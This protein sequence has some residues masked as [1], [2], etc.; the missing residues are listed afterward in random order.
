MTT[1]RIAVPIAAVGALAAAALLMAQ[2]SV[3]DTPH[4]LSAS[5]PSAVRATGEEKVCIFCHTPHSARP[6][7]PLWNRDNPANAYTVYTSNALDA[8]PGQPTGTSKMCL[9]CHDG[10]IALGSVVSQDQSIQMAG[11][12]TT[13]PPGSSNLGTDLSDDHPISFP[14]DASLVATDLKLTDPAA[15]TSEIRLDQNQELQC[16]ACHDAHDNSFGEFLVMS[17]EGSALC[18][19]CHQISTTTVMGHE[20]CAGCH[21]THTAPS[22]PYLLAGDRVRS[23]CLRCH[24]GSAPPAKDIA[25]D[26][27]KFNAHDTDSPVDPPNPVPDHATCADCHDPHTMEHGSGTAPNIHPSFGK[28]PG[29]NL[30]GTA[31][32][33]AAFE[34]E[35]CYRCHADTNVADASWVSRQLTQINTRLEFDPTAVSFHPVATTGRNP[36]VPSLRPPWTEA[37]IVY[38]SDCHG[39][40]NSTKIGG[41]GPDGVHGS[42]FEPIL[43]ARYETTDFTPESRSAYALCYRCHEREGTDG[44]LRDRTFEHSKHVEDADTPCSVCHDPHGIASAQGRAMNNSHLINFDTTVV[45]AD[46]VTGLLEFQD[47]GE[48]AGTCTLMC[49]GE[50][51]DNTSYAR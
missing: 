34:Y 13:I 22:G 45:S 24:D 31:I 42:F 26:I 14:Y 37:S 3:I 2:Q 7:S 23:T 33:E 11:G 17:N 10:T 15:L 27:Q 44:V 40:D 43:V 41:N 28:V 12:I 21:Q 25:T 19:A 9:S 8:I 50:R 29:V 20:T 47:L 32:I 39:S 46:P 4:N 36:D 38:C 30:S 49:H 35:V 6:I 16:T 51:H 1:A 5:G 18:V 48:R